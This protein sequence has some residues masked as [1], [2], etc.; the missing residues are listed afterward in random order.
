[1]PRMARV[2]DLTGLVSVVGIKLGYQ[3]GHDDK[4][5]SEY[6]GMQKWLL[7]SYRVSEY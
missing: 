7:Q 4:L 5:Y 3:P 2:W 6:D 1:M